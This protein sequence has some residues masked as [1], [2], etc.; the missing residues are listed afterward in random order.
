[1]ASLGV[2]SLALQNPGL[3]Y[4]ERTETGGYIVGNPSSVDNHVHV[5]LIRDRVNEFS[6]MTAYELDNNGKRI[7]EF[8][9]ILMDLG[10]PHF[11]I[12]AGA[13]IEFAP[14]G[15]QSVYD[16]RQAMLAKRQAD[17]EA[18]L[19]KAKTQFLARDKARQEEA[20]AKPAPAGT[21]VAIQAEACSAMGDGNVGIVANRRSAVG[22]CI[23]QWDAAGQWV[24]W[25]FDAPAEGYYHLTLCYCSEL[26]LIEREIKVNGEVQEPF[27]PMVF[28]STGGWANG[29]DDWRL[30]TA[31]SP[32]SGDPLLIKFKQGKNV[33]RLTNLNG[34]GIN[35]DWLAVTSPDVKIDRGA[36]AGKLK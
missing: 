14:K 7:G 11:T 15:A 30:L 21:I 1:V 13:R 28:P 34:R 31:S 18:E 9:Q 4:V 6:T 32:V 2:W 16:F 3:A 24:E 22:A 29:S 12:K 33:I 10:T 23:N 25:T 26:D 20:K 17:Q 8:R 36:L 35:V 19:A 27:A 5:L